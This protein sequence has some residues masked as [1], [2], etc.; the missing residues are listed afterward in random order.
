MNEHTLKVLEYDKV[1]SL[2]AGFAASEPGRASVLELLPALSPVVVAE[3]LQETQESISLFMSGENLPLDGIMNIGPSVAKLRMNGTMLSPQ[4]LL[5]IAGTLGAGRRIKGFF[6]RI[7]NKGTLPREGFPLL[8]TRAAVIQPLPQMEEAIGTAIDEKA[9][10]KDSASPALRR[11]RKQIS[12]MRDDIL[13]RLSGI[14]QDGAL[15][16]VVQEQ[17]ITMRDDRYVLPLKPNFRQN[18]RG[19]VHGQSGS[20]STLFVEPLEVLE[21]NN[22]LA[23][24]RMEER[25][26]VER[27]LRELTGMLAQEVERI[28]VMIGVLAAIDA[29]AARARFGIEY[30]AAVPVVSQQGEVRFR[31]ARHPLLVW[32]AKAGGR[33]D[34]IQPNDIVIGRDARVLILSGPN[35]GGKT[36]VLKTVGV[37]CLMAQAGM[38]VTAA[39]GSELPCFG[40]FFADIGD[41]QSLEQNLSTFSSHV[42]QIAEILRLADE[43][44]LVL[45]DELGSGTDPAEGA[46]LGAAVLE[47]LIERGCV[48]MITTHQNALKLFGAETGGAVNAAM[49][50]DP[51][52]LQPTYRLTPGRP[53][54]SYGLDMAAR[55]G[56][57][58][59]V[60]KRARARL[61]DDEVRLETLLRQVEQ[62]AQQLAKER[63]VLATGVALVRRQQGEAEAALQTAKNEAVEVRGRAHRDAREVLAQLRQKLREFSSV[64]VLEP[65]VIKSVRSDI[66]SLVRTLEPEPVERGRVPSGGRADLHAG[67]QVRVP[68]LARSGTVLSLQHGVL[69]I[70]LDG[71][72]VKIAAEE[73]VPGEKGQLRKTAAPGW[74][75]DLHE[76]EQAPDRLN[77]LGLRVEESLA[78]V[79]RY[80][81]RVGLTGLSVVTIIHGLGTGAL[82]TALTGYLKHH[83]LVA[84]TRTGEPAE[85]G[86]GVTV[87]ELKK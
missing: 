67:D 23:E 6:D 26:E 49:E 66:E 48:T 4:E 12:R 55:L 42:S 61:S 35:A 85:G 69:E 27:I 25:D 44:S 9:E 58:D 38:P 8:R 46:G 73:A 11:V 78:E 71:K 59:A 45:L 76:Q 36:A 5:E 10:I 84:A 77:L 41:E 68:R 33:A 20:R 34:R 52:T 62:D 86:A 57:P 39:A 63:E 70:E 80:L 7:G 21:Q 3:L 14:L 82:K 40:S 30:G 19:V 64:Q 1:R 87:V 60:I 75:A 51:E 54:R 74:S 47:N 2:V 24:L 31:S 15:Q 53:G 17:V 79:D 50:F 28:E 22:R 37:L 72:T 13:G 43:H 81:D 32:K 29:I 16:K 56:I 83:P 65:S 18:I